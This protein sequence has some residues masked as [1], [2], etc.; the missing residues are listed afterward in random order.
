MT[1]RALP[2]GRWNLLRTQSQ[3]VLMLKILPWPPTAS[4]LQSREGLG[5]GVGSVLCLATFRTSSPTLLRPVVAILLSKES[6]PVCEDKRKAGPEDDVWSLEPG[7][8]QSR[9]QLRTLQLLEPTEGLVLL[10]QLSAGFLSP[11]A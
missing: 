7:P 3:A 11:A 6:L 8:A 9:R 4:G 1:I 2:H 10:K 5:V